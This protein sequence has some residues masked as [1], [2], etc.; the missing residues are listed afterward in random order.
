[1]NPS[2]FLSLPMIP[3]GHCYLWQPGLVRLHVMADSLTAIAYYSIPIVLTVFAAKRKDVPFNRVFWLFAAFIFACGTTHLMAIWTIWH[4]DY[5]LEGLIKAITALVSVWTALTLTGTIKQALK[6]P[7]LI[8][9]EQANQEL[10]AEVAV[11]R[12][13]ETQLQNLTTRLQLAVQSA[14]IGIWEWQVAT[15]E[16]SW[17]DR[18]YELYGISSTDFESAYRAWETRVHPDDEVAARTA[19]QQA[20]QGEQDFNTEFR[21]CWP[22]GTVHYIEAHALVQKDEAEQSCRMIGVNWDITQRRQTEL[23]LAQEVRLSKTLFEASIDGIVL[24]KHQ[25]DVLQAS[26]SF[27]QMLGYSLAEI[28]TLNIV[29]WDAQWTPEELQT[30]LQGEMPL[31]PRFETRHRRQDGSIYDVEISYSRAVLNGETVHFCICRDISE[32]KQAE[33]ERYR[34]SHVLEASLNEIYLFDRD[35]LQFEY[36]NQGA[37]QNLGYSLAQLRQLTPLAIKPELSAADFNA[38]ITPLLQGDRPQVKFETVHQRADGTCYPVEVRIQLTPY[39][40]QQVFLAIILDISDRQK[41]E[42]QLIHQARHDSLTDLPNRTLLTERLDLAL[43]RAHQ[44]QT[45]RYAVLFLDLDQFKVINDSLGHQV[46]DQLLITVARELQAIVRPTD[47]VARLGGDEFVILLEHL[48]SIQVATQMAER[49]RALFSV[50]LALAE[51]SVFITTSLGLVWGRRDYTEAADL[52]RDADIAMYRAKVGGR[53]RYEIFDVEMHVQVMQ[54]QLLEQDLRLAIEQQ[55]FVVHYQPIIELQ[56]RRL[57]GFEALLRWPHPTRGFIAPDSFIPVAEETGLIWNISQWVMQAACEQLAAWRRQFPTMEHLKVSVN[58]SG[59]DL[60]QTTLRTTILQILGQ[61]Q[62]PATSLTLEITESL[63]IEN[64]HTTIDLLEQLRGLGIRISIDDF[65]TGY[66]SL[67]YLYNLPADS[68][69]IDKSFVSHMQPGNT[70]YKIVQAVTHLSD[71][72]GLSAIAE[73]IET[74]QQLSWLEALGC[75]LG[76]GYLLSRPLS[77]EAATAFLAAQAI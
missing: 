60:L 67:S 52:L 61:T 50:P 75:E 29:D 59:R 6:L 23:D 11:R 37:L 48:P 38:L 22:D 65:G 30:I 2:V 70:N 66:S 16:L 18:M 39:A 56:T 76:Q 41:A 49:I 68:L 54:R 25:G 47:L 12:Q 26:T 7:E 71:Q 46:G 28:Y 36:A 31:P 3:H 27:A 24:L 1:M 34:L 15:D 32:R 45:Y 77:T 21:V 51:H 8:S 63:L 74:P 9:V 33:A 53:N 58:L 4:P 72:L 35:T 44:S 42:A 17:D 57:A 62:V 55:Q 73:G 13:V 69:K 5:W 14:H 10:R 19:I 20:L 43:K 40:G 64:I